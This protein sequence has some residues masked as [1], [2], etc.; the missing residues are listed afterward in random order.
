MDTINNKIVLKSLTN[1]MIVVTVQGTSYTNKEIHLYGNGSSWISNKITAQNGQVTF[2]AAQQP[3][4]NYYE[5]Y[6][7]SNGTNESIAAQ[8]ILTSFV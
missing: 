2:I 8:V 1:V 3:V 7:K 6:I 5:V 4:N